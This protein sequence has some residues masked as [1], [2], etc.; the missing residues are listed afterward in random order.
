MNV[1]E[2]IKDETPA[3]LK[4]RRR[5]FKYFKKLLTSQGIIQ[6]C[7]SPLKAED[8]LGHPP[9]S[10]GMQTLNVEPACGLRHGCR[11]RISATR[12]L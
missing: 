3:T 6:F 9:Q 4:G 1:N 11:L 8:L 12:V 2:I 7:I 10:L 5:S